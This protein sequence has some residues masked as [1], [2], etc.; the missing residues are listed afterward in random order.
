VDFLAQVVEGF[1]TAISPVNVFYCFIGVLFGT[2]TG[3]LPG[4][5][6]P[7][8][9]A[10]LLPL[11]LAMDPVTALIMLAGIYYGTQYG[12][13]ISS[14]LV[15]TPGDS[16]TV[17]TTIDGYQ[18]ARNGRAG[19][20]LAVAAVAS[21]LAGTISIILLMT[22]A[23]PLASLAINFGPPETFAL[24]VVGL[25]G[26]IGFTGASRAKGLAMAALG[27]AIA[28][29]G[30]DPS[31]GETRFAFG[32]VQ[33]YGGIGFLEVTIGLFAIA[34]LVTQL[35][36]GTPDPIRA[37]YREMLLTWNDWRRSRLPILRGGLLGFMVGTIPGVG[38]T[39]AS[40]LAYDLERRVSRRKEEFGKGAIEGVAAPEA[41]NNAAS[42]AAF[43]P[44]LTLGIPSSATAAV[45]LGAFLLFGIQPGPLLIEE[46][47]E[48]VWG[49]LAS[50]YIG[51]IILLIMNLPLA[52]LFASMLRMRYEMMYP[53]I[54]LLSFLGAFAVENRL[55]GVWLALAFGVI[56]FFMKRYDY[57]APPVILGIII[58][59][60][61]EEALVQTSSISGGD[62][63]IFLTRPIA[64]M[65]FALAFVIIL[66]PFII[67]AVKSLS[68][69]AAVS[70]R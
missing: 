61:M 39:L 14:V 11:T 7:T 23:P 70:E 6:S 29:V 31:T 27:L 18:L 5:G 35:K 19:P 45:L 58:G 20:A 54:L 24:G 33:L 28:T 30:L 69:R 48:V 36:T 9:V 2:I 22:V 59:G 55:W 21:F 44:L 67:K 53:L 15:A 50:F 25:A 46:Q 8:A 68:R 56:G 65:L 1:Q 40:F 38:A 43:V 16:S 63:T 49:L 57:P 12:A 26:V 66:G 62:F 3:L 34:E 32:N 64:L 10:L 60:I 47:P 52:P 41:A 17:V 37:R 4:L 51:N 42:N 13:T